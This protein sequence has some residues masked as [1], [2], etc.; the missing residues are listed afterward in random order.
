[1]SILATQ[2]PHVSCSTKP[3]QSIWQALINMRALGRQRHALKALEPHLLN[4]IGITQAQ[5]QQE[6]ATPIWKAPKH[7]KK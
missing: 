1:M 3:R 6:T 4:D 2:Q 5:V 7:W